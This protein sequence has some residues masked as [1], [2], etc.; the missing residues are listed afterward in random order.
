[1]KDVSGK[2][3]IYHEGISLGLGQLLNLDLGR[4]LS[5]DGRDFLVVF[6]YR[7][8]LRRQFVKTLNGIFRSLRRET[9][10]RE[11]RLLGLTVLSL[12]LDSKQREQV[13]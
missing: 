10:K 6:D 12:S 7:L 2:K 8:V 1:M 3:P 5:T 11:H 9:P 4:F 13:T